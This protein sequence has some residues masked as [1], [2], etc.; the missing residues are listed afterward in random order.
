MKVGYWVGHYPSGIQSQDY[1]WGG[2]GEAAAGLAEAVVRLGHDV[3]VITSSPTTRGSTRF[4]AGVRVIELPSLWTISQTKVAPATLWAGL[5]LEFDVVHAHLDNPPTPFGA[6]IYHL[7]RGAPLVVTYHGDPQPQYGRMSRRVLVRLYA[8]QPLKT[9]LNHANL[10]TV[11]SAEFV[12]QSRVLRNACSPL[13]EVPNGIR[14]DPLV[15]APT[16]E[17]ARKMLAVG[18]SR[19]IVLFLGSMNPYKRPDVLFRAATRAIHEGFDAVF[20]FAG[21]GMMVEP[22]RA[23]ARELGLTDSV[24]IL[25][26]VPESVKHALL[27]AADL[28]VL[29]STMTQEVFPVAILEAFSAGVPVIASDL[30]SLRRIIQNGVNGLLVPVE[31]DAALSAVI[32]SLSTDEPLRAQLAL[33]AR[34]SVSEFSWTRIA[35]QVEALY[36]RV[37][38]EQPRKS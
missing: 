21:G 19:H 16:K 24:R 8:N 9:L 20:F 25:G 34:E 10:V 5:P 23:K 22:L 29:P 30:K 11:P 26:F 13:V 32:R 33:R 38:H 18:E 35:S 28:F 17:E 27:S 7:I 14:H 36:Q 2:S 1:F 31:D 15:L 12:S 6:L 37:V 4:Q 3:T